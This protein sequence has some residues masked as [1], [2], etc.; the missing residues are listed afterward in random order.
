M[1]LVLL[2]LFIKSIDFYL[3]SVTYGIDAVIYINNIQ[4]LQLMCIF[5]ML[6]LLF[7][8][9]TMLPYVYIFI[10]GGDLDLFC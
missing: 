2:H 8:L 9:K 4:T 7:V 10:G 6:M 1:F 5:I 3:L